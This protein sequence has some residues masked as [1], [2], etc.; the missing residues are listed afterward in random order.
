MFYP[1]SAT[2]MYSKFELNLFCKNNIETLTLVNKAIFIGDAE[3]RRRLAYSIIYYQGINMWSA[4]GGLGVDETF[5]TQLKRSCV[6]CFICLYR[7]L[8]NKNNIDMCVLTTV[9]DMILELDSIICPGIEI[10][11]DDIENYERRCMIM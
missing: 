1:V 4:H 10:I 9:S 3:I 8:Y 5:S 7:Y 2:N 11:D 6:K